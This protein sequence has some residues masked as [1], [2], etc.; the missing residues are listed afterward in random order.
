MLHE[1]FY[2]ILNMSI[3][4]TLYGILLYSLRL[5][6]GFP[7]YGSYVLWGVVFLRLTCPVGFSSRYSLLSLLSG[8]FS[9]TMIRTVT[10]YEVSTQD[11]FQL[12][13]SNVV[14]AASDYHPVT[15]KTNILEGFF[16]TASAI[17]IIIAMAGIL[18]TMIL[19]LLS[20]SELK[21]AVHL[22]D[23]IYIGSMVDTPIVYGI[24]KPRI[25]LPEGSYPRESQ[26]QVSHCMNVEQGELQESPGQAPLCE[27]IE[28]EQLQGY[29]ENLSL[30]ENTERDQLQ[31]SLEQVMLHE[32]IHIKRR[33]NLWRMAAILTAC[34][35]WFNPFVW[36]FL[37]S[38]Q[39]DCELACDAK[40]VKHMRTEERKDY[41][42]AL[43]AYGSGEKTLFSSA[44]G[45]GIVKV[46]IR[47]VLTY[48]RLT[49]FSSLCFLVMALLIAFLLLTNQA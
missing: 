40:A 49:V 13:L 7:R 25:V 37:R 19:Y 36:F 3:L 45:S 6:K 33:D 18:T 24:I 43:L 22:R 12:S 35:H 11:Q 21:K 30:C 34:I 38:F 2:W 39:R 29:P 9:Q 23:N 1:V 31:K 46:R 42:R 17:W 26:G 4:G 44:F 16:K 10:I 14:R 15:Y 20:V 5:I 28:R 41:A 8:A 47:S 48:R 32:R 27:S